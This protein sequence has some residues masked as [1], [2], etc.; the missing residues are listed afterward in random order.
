M[1]VSVFGATGFIGEYIVK[2][3]IN[4]NP[5]FNQKNIRK[6]LLIDR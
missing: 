1:K 2:E 5:T 3:L 4:N 6:A